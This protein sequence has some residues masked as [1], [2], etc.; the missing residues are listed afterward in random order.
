MSPEPP[1]ASPTAEGYYAHHRSA[2]ERLFGTRD[3]AITADQLRV[4]SAVYPIVRD[5]I[6]LLPAG[7][8]SPA[9][10]PRSAADAPHGSATGPIATDIRDTFGAE[11]QEYPEILP[12]HEREFRQ[13]F[14]LVPLDSLRGKRVADLGCGMGRWSYFLREVC[15][16]LVLVDFSDAIF[17]ARHNLRDCPRALFFQA[18]LE[19]LPFV[20]DAFDFAFSLGVLHHLSTPALVATRRL[21]P[22]A[23][24]LLVYL[25]Y[26]LDNRPAHF[27]VLLALATGLRS[28]LW[29]VR[30]E[31]FRRAF[32][33]GVALLVYRPL[34]GLGGL[35]Q[36][37]G[38]GR[39]VP[40]YDFYRGQSA[41]RIRQD[42][43][44]RFFT[45]IE[46]RVSRRQ[47]L[48]LRDTFDEVRVS[49]G[50]PYWHFLCRRS[51]GA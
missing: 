28:A 47:I 21:R 39:F 43:Y 40:L 32:A 37:A 29:R 46:Q 18:D 14:D 19:Q 49:E 1:T 51:G 10:G 2:L 27:R 6:Q 16:E 7:A 30:S 8:G 20:H 24:S 17:V 15:D 36:L 35:A 50:L 23:P 12:E 45:R 31:R 25:Y 38:L 44:D 4:G 33:S 5:V 48:E 13:Y 3:L 9:E 22:L 42:V 26:A 34:I 11:W 41:R